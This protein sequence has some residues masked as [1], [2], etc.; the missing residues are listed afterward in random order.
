METE[1]S[2]DQ[3]TLFRTVDVLDE[4]AEETGK[5]IAQVAL[6]WVLQRPTVSSIIFGARDERQLVENFGSVG[7]NLTS[8]QVARLDAASAVTPI[9]PYWHQA[10][11]SRERNPFPTDVRSPSFTSG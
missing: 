5:T 1:Q 4:L 3:E 9:Y 11:H 8:D 10:Q 2:G 7:W 6:N